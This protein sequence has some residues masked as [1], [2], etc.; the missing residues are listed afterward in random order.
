M[1]YSFASPAKLEKTESI[2]PAKVKV[3]A[4]FVLSWQSWSLP[5]NQ[6]EATCRSHV[7][8]LIPFRLQW[9]Y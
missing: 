4:A 8:H 6:H 2:N 3:K 1:Q 9:I 7:L 5:V